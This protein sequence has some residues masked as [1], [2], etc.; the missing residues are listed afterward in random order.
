MPNNL[1][2]LAIGRLCD[3]SG[4]LGLG[5]AFAVSQSHALTAFH[6]IGNYKTGS[7]L[8]QQVLLE[9]PVGRR[10][11]AEYEAGDHEADYAMLS[12]KSPLPTGFAPVPLLPQTFPY[13]PFRC[14]GY[15]S[16]LQGPDITSIGGKVRTAESSIFGGVPAIQLFA[17]EAAAGLSLQGL[18]GSPVL[19]RY[20]EA[21]IG[22]IRWNPQRITAP[23]L[24]VG[25]IV[26]CCP[27]RL[28]IDKRQ[29]LAG[30]VA[31]VKYE[32]KIA[33][34]L[35]VLAALPSTDQ[36][37]LKQAL[38]ELHREKLA[39][40]QVRALEPE[41]TA[42]PKWQF[43]LPI[44]DQPQEM[45]D[46]FMKTVI[47]TIA[48]GLEELIPKTVREAQVVVLLRLTISGNI[49]RLTLICPWQELVAYLLDHTPPR[50]TVEQWQ[51]DI[52]LSALDLRHQYAIVD[53]ALTPIVFQYKPVLRQVLATN[54]NQV[55]SPDQFLSPHLCKTT[56]HFL[57]F[58]GTLSIQT[59]LKFPPGTPPIFVVDNFEQLFNS[60][61]DHWFS[62]FYHFLDTGTL[63]D[64]ERLFIGTKDSEQYRYHYVPTAKLDAG[65]PTPPEGA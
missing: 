7:V 20:P 10:V 27:V 9:F 62:W 64:S 50:A 35:Q 60:G 53:G 3:K 26:F 6:C 14:A 52:R 5:T 23:E 41:W 56:S 65:S 11:D 54:Q 15:P 34:L 46:E 2:S 13:E 45:K 36:D 19:V 61:L 49:W 43:A 18:S 44:G 51:K 4:K 48:R 37:P 47:R 32:D 8:H 63:F 40:T 33:E 1:T 55:S 22:L 31:Q 30:S 16:S 25:G 28:I 12:L 17:D 57:N 21:A 29:E 39:K 58:L 59:A 24:G 38:S 42:I